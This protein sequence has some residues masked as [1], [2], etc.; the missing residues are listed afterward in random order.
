MV[1]RSAL[2]E[3]LEIKRAREERYFDSL[4]K[5][6][7]APKLRK[8]IEMYRD[9][10][11]IVHGHLSD[12]KTACETLVKKKGGY[13][14]ELF[15][16]FVLCLGKYSKLLD[17]EDHRKKALSLVEYAD[18]WIRPIDTWVVK[19]HNRDRQFS[20]L[21]RHLFTE[22]EM[23]AFLD[24]AWDGNRQ[25][26]GVG[27]GWLDKFL[28]SHIASGNN[29][30]TAVLLPVT[31]T[32]MIAHFFLQAQSYC[33]MHHAIKWAQIRALGVDERLFRAIRETRLMGYD[34]DYDF[35][36]SIFRFFIENPMLDT[37]QIGPIVDY[38]WN[39]KYH[40]R[41]R[42]NPDG[43]I[44]VEPPEQPNFS[45]HKRTV[46]SL[47]A[48][49]QRWHRQL[50]KEIKGKVAHKWEHHP[51]IKDFKMTEGRVES[52]NQKIWTITQLMSSSELAAEGRALRHCVASYGHSCARGAVSI[53]SM[54]LE[55]KHG[56]GRCVTIE[57]RNKQICQVRGKNNRK[58]EPVESRIMSMWAK[59]E[60]LTISTYYGW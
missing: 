44:E 24:N 50:G 43:V 12:I 38:I 57:V 21:V 54:C 5:A 15:F 52:K 30:L 4:R 13:Y 29:I 22:Y 31:L 3:N 42:V 10:G 59:T 26:Y 40:D 35:I 8:A 36:L 33:T 34:K 18:K 17:S 23:P 19:S 39:Q 20:S 25:M 46:E 27:N 41:R 28:F 56:F 45:M 7:K 53:W 51:T 60:N 9:T 2:S 49:V 48:Q 1:C 37:D 58:I 6:K 47:L 32:K 11:Q 16:D 55:D 14:K